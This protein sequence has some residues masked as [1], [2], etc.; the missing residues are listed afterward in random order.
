MKKKLLG[1]VTHPLFI[2]LILTSVLLYITYPLFP[3]YKADLVKKEKVHSNHFSYFS[4][5]DN[6]GYSEEIALDKS[7]KDKL[8]IIVKSKGSIV[9]QWIIDGIFNMQEL[10]FGDFNNDG[11]KEIFLLTIYKNEILLNC[12]N[13]FER[14]FYITNKLIDIFYPKNNEKNTSFVFSE[15]YDLNGDGTKELVFALSAGFSISPRSLYSYNILSDD[16]KRSKNGCISFYHVEKLD[17]LKNDSSYY[18]SSNYAVGNC[19]SNLIHSDYHTWLTVF[20]QNLNFKFEPIKIGFHP[21]DLNISP[22]VINDT[23]YIVVLNIYHGN[24]NHKSTIALYN[25]NGVKINEKQIVYSADWMGARILRNTEESDKLYLIKTTGSIEEISSNLTFTPINE[26]PPFNETIT[27]KIDCD[28][29]GLGEFI[30]FH[31]ELEKITILRSNFENQLDID[32]IGN[33]EILYKSC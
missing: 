22:F 27:A 16:L 4:D 11:S 24:S 28:Q 19:D 9:D 20:N 31:R 8:S 14:K 2:S 29:D 17:D 7:Y 30:V 13:P 6:D 33:N 1:F 23:I 32:V 10:F 15:L 21:S 5:L 26:V 12:F 3:K 25:F 18:F